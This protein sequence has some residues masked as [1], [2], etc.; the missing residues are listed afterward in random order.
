MAKSRAA[1]RPLW[2]ITKHQNGRIGV[3]TIRPGVN[4]EV[5]PVFSFEEEAETFLQ[6][7]APEW[8]VREATGRELISMLHGPCAGVK[9]VALDPLPL[10]VGGEEMLGLVSMTRERFVMGLID[11]HELSPTYQGHSR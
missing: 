4:R 2:L 9:K 6:L 8:S 11:K 5:L 7:G 1:P 10:E 3:L